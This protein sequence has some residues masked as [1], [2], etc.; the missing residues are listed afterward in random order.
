MNEEF[1][2]NALSHGDAGKKWLQDLPLIIAQ[3][4]D[5]WSL[6]VSP[7]FNLN[8]NY[9][10]PTTRVDGSK[11][12]LKIGFPLDEEFQKEI[13]ALGLF[14]G[15][16]MVKLLEIDED[17]QAILLEQ[18]I[19]GTP[20]SSLEDDEEA[21][22][23]L[24]LVMKKIWKPLPPR[25]SFTTVEQW[26]KAI[27][28]YQ[29]KFKDKEGPIPGFL[30]TKAEEL[31][32]ELIATSLEPVLLHGDL[33]H[34]NVLT[35]NRDQWLAIDPKGIAGEPAF[36]TAAMIRN[37]YGKM[38]KQPNLKK[39]LT[40]RIAILTDELGIDRKRILKWSFAQTV[41]SA[42]WNVESSKGPEHAVMIATVLDSLK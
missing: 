40:R 2:Q 6:K 14:S 16:G 42:V 11:V 31:F 23:I 22:R 19:P 17:N 26:S 10:A 8:Y 1:R 13:A 29:D 27:S 24:A 32:K 7:P 15:E 21:T 41:L 18:V 5:K 25:H 3:C 20:L 9:V 34:D 35:S 28:K 37:P 39:T 36:E 12:V 30:V 4:R 33:H 38:S